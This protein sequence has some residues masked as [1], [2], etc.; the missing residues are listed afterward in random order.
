MR[1]LQ[2]A[3]KWCLNI[4]YLVHQ[5]LLD[6]P[7]LYLSRYIIQ[8][9]NDYYNL[10]QEVR[11]KDNW[12]NWILYM[13]KGI[14]VTASD[15]LNRINQIRDLMMDYKHRIRKQFK[16]YSQDLLNNLFCHPYTKI[17]FLEK[18]LDVTRQTASKYL[19]SLSDEGFLKKMKIG[20][21]IYY[22][23]EPLC[24]F[25]ISPHNWS[26]RLGS[27]RYQD[28]KQII[29]NIRSLPYSNVSSFVCRYGIFRSW[30]NEFLR[31]IFYIF[32]RK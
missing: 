31:R 22:I 1:C 32:F 14:E 17:E 20:V 12:E 21:N 15:T 9:K 3:E 7:V 6:I 27:Q 25:R 18:D 19:D 23:N 24:G 26:S 16:F 4:L 2:P 13:L 28:Y 11:I 10:L 5:G 8:H 29:F 30:V